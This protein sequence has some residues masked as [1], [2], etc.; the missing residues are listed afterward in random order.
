MDVLEDPC[1]DRSMYGPVTQAWAK[2]LDISLST[3]MAQGQAYNKSETDE[4]QT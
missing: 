2:T 1:V 3:V 4:S